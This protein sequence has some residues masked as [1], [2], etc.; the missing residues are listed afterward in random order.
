MYMYGRTLRGI[1]GLSEVYNHVGTVLYQCMHKAQQPLSSTL[2]PNQWL[3]ARKVVLPMPVKDVNF[4]LTKV[5]KCQSTLQLPKHLKHSAKTA[6]N[7]DL[8]DLS[9]NN[10]GEFYTKL[11]TQ[12]DNHPN[13]LSIHQQTVFAGFTGFTNSTPSTNPHI[14]VFTR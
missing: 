14:A 12:R 10:Q 5:H 4:A 11:S 9:E 7:L 13:I 3:P 6:S 1:Q 8:G 2:L